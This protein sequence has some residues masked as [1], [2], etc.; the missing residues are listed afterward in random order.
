MTPLPADQ[1]RGSGHL[2]SKIASVAIAGA[3]VAKPIA[4]SAHQLLSAISAGGVTAIVLAGVLVIIGLREVLAR[5]TH[6]NFGR[7]GFFSV[8]D[9]VPIPPRAPRWG[10]V[11][12]RLLPHL[13]ALV[14]GTMLLLPYLVA[15][16]V[17]GVAPIPAVNQ[18][19]ALLFRDGSGPTVITNLLATY[20]T[21]DLLRLW[22]GF[23]FW[24]CSPPIYLDVR[25]SR[26]DLKAVAMENRNWRRSARILSGVLW[27]PERLLRALTVFDGAM[28]WMGG[29]ALIA[30]GGFC[31]L[32]TFVLIRSLLDVLCA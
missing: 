19:P 3:G 31:V 25:R 28:V 11:S 29:N 9:P 22:G 32:G 30:T 14:I 8:F 17:L 1:P 13:L 10:R 26:E 2:T 20:G 27:L 23:A 4:K 7:P 21:L 24:Y 15:F 16:E 18:D 5:L 6:V 12:V